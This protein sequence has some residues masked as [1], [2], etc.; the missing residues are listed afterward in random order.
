MHGSVDR[1]KL[2]KKEEPLLKLLLCVNI[3]F[4]Y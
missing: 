3:V 1:F 4:I 2:P